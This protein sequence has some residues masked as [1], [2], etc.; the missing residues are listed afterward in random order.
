M[1]LNQLI[2]P[3]F[4][5]G[6]S[7]IFLGDKS[8]QQFMQEADVALKADEDTLIKANK[9]NVA[10]LTV[11][12][13]QDLI[14]ARKADIVLAS[15]KDAALAKPS[16]DSGVDAVIVQSDTPPEVETYKQRPIIHG[17]GKDFLLVASRRGVEQIFSAERELIFENPPPLDV[18]QFKREF[19]AFNGVVWCMLRSIRPK[20]S[21][22]DYS[23]FRRAQMFREHLGIET[24]LITHEYQN[25]LLEQRDAYGI[26]FP[27]LNMYDYFQEVNRDSEPKELPTR[28]VLSYDDE[29]RATR[30]DTYDMLGFLSRRQELDPTNLRP[31]EVTYYRP[32]GTPAIHEAYD[33]IDGKNILTLTELINRQGEVTKSFTEHEE[34]LSYWLMEMLRDKT[35]NY[36]LIDDRAPDWNEAY[37]AIEAAGL[38]NVRVIHQLHNIHVGGDLN[39]LTAPTKERY[40]YLTDKAIRTDAILSLTTQQTEDLLQRYPL[41]NVFN[42][43]HPLPKVDAV[44][45]EVNPFLVVQVGRITKDKQHAKAIDVFRIVLNK[46][47]QAQLHFY[48]SG[49]LQESLQAK[50]DSLGLGASSVFKGFTD[51]IAQ[52]F[53]SAALS[54]L[55]SLKEGSP[56]VIQ[57]SL[58]NNCP[59]V[60]FDCRYGPR[61]SIV[62][63]VNGYLV[64]V[65][66]VEALADRIIKILTEPGLRDKLSANCARSVEKYSPEKV[67]SKWIKLFRMFMQR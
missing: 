44:K 31:Y 62:D 45:A 8:N 55:P 36:F 53:A 42:I 9:L 67:A 13:A 26:N 29:Q 4:L 61:D 19:K 59:V 32:D 38:D 64:A 2:P 1:F 63:G 16:I 21:G 20:A 40:I 57:E 47:P 28:F 56:L 41:P 30:R 43:P 58:Q 39:P 34:A 12:D 15:V 48:G 23:A 5:K 65:N 3:P 14:A 52:V 24:H 46:V 51:N 17:T 25:D 7:V 18:E 60:A 33:L 54:I 37:R 22:I 49:S 27:V 35:Q 66:D 6:W 50:I 11:N 10:L